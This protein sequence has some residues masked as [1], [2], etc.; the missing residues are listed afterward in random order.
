VARRPSREPLDGLIRLAAWRSFGPLA[1]ITSRRSTAARPSRPSG[2]R[3]LIDIPTKTPNHARPSPSGSSRSATGLLR[4]STSS[5]STVTRTV[6]AGPDHS[7]STSPRGVR[8]VLFSQGPGNGASTDPK[9]HSRA[10]QDGHRRG[11]PGCSPGTTGRARCGMTRTVSQRGLRNGQRIDHACTRP[12]RGHTREDLPE[13]IRDVIPGF[14]PYQRR[15]RP[16]GAAGRHQGRGSPPRRSRANGSARARA[17]RRSPHPCGIDGPH[18][19][20]PR[21]G[22]SAGS[23]SRGALLRPGPLRTV[24]AR[25]PSTRL[26]QAGQSPSACRDPSSGATALGPFTTEAASNLSSGSHASPTSPSG[27][28]DPVSILSGPGTSPYPASYPRPRRWRPTPCE[29]SVCCRLSAH[30]H[31]LLG[32]P[33][34]LRSWPQPYGRCAGYA[35]YQPHVTAWW[36]ACSAAGERARL[37]A[38]AG[39][40]WLGLQPRS[41]AP[42]AVPKRRHQITTVLKRSRSTSAGMS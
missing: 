25:H 10:E 35:V 18:S 27:S 4:S 9:V 11:T 20:A 41:A 29:S 16:G 32:H 36:L 19:S 6:R 40:G 33:V 37:A 42:N 17:G 23:G 2:P 15:R 24:H 8:C 26:K 30:R 34:P 31:S 5:G 14:G 21:N 22:T 38:T 3:A 28:P 1:P 7:R 13:S 39:P 12:R